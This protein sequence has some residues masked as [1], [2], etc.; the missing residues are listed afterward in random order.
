MGLHSYER[1]ESGL[2]YT[3]SVANLGLLGKLQSF[4]G[5]VHLFRLNLGL[6]A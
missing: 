4:M 1:I 3:C 6:L 5:S 2:F